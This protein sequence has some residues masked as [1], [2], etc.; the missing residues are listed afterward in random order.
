L[1][2][3]RAKVLNLEYDLTEKNEKIFTLETALKN[4]QTTTHSK[5]SLLR[6]PPSLLLTLLPPSLP[7]PHVCYSDG[8]STSDLKISPEEIKTLE[9]SLSKKNEEINHLQSDIT[10]LQLEKQEAE[11]SGSSSPPPP[12]SLS[13]THHSTALLGKKFYEQLRALQ[14]EIESEKRKL[15]EETNANSQQTQVESEA[16]EAKLQELNISNEELIEKLS[17]QSTQ[18]DDL[19]TQLRTLQVCSSLPSI[20]LPRSL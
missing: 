8:E 6:C 10:R 2:Q 15:Q 5:G 4:N 19:S 18:C 14:K 3:L 1:K 12:P 7:V 13:L 9:L 16:L 11:A 20:S 17:E